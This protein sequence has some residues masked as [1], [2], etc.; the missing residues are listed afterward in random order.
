MLLLSVGI[1]S[2]YSCTVP[3]KEEAVI[4]SYP[5][6]TD[7]VLNNPYMGFVVDARDNNR[8]SQ[9]FR[10]VHA[11]L[12]WRELEPQK[13]VYNFEELERKFRFEYWRQQ[14]VKLVMRVVLDYPREESHMD[15]PD[16]LYEETGRQ[17]VWYAIEYGRGFSPDY[18]NPLLIS[19]HAKLIAALADRYRDDPFVA[20]IQL[21][22][23]GHWG[24][25]H[26]M[27]HGPN[28]IAF[29]KRSVTDRYVIPYL[30]EFTGKHLLMRRPTAIA[31]K[32]GM[33]LFNDAFGNEETIAGGFRDWYMN[34]YTS[35]LTG[36]KEPAMPDFWK[37]SPSGGEFSERLAAFSDDRI[38]G[39]LLQAKLTHVSWMGPSAP[40][41][42]EAGGAY[43][44]NINRFLNA[45]GYRFAVTKAEYEQERK[46]GETLHVRYV[47]ANRGAAP[48]YFRWPLELSLFDQ[49]GSM[50]ASVRSSADIRAWLPGLHRGAVYLTVPADLAPGTY[51]VH[52]AILD[53]ETGKP[54]IDFAMEGR[55]PDGRYRLGTVMVV[56]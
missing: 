55:Q 3:A 38:E 36:E 4:S 2:G 6:E 21:G 56:Q 46:P 7:Q 42:A 41:R 23:I 20:F 25:W 32:H 1:L 51:G 30:Q 33:G 28:P 26:T 24:E 39:T 37:K 50:A 8:A 14:G 12:F 54:G 53:P 27:D 31:A 29:P 48:F 40:W 19:Y 49:N 13:G 11:N 44:E 45:I 43:Q 18:T 52:V 9:P 17:G 10:L 35:W 47:M 22:S 5:L 15:I 16:W 34:G